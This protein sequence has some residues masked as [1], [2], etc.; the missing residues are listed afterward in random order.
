MQYERQ[1]RGEKHHVPDEK[2]YSCLDWFVNG[3]PIS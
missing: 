1:L 3:E 2:F